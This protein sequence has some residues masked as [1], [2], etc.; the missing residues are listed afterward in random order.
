[1]QVLGRGRHLLSFE[2]VSTRCIIP[3]APKR[4]FGMMHRDDI[5]TVS[6]L[7]MLVFTLLAHGLLQ[8][9][10]LV[11]SLGMMMTKALISD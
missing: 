7:P 4:D 6:P 5:G 8:L 2:P 10:V 1:M 11:V 9:M 3:I